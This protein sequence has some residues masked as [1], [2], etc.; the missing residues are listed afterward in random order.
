MTYPRQ[1]AYGPAPGCP[2][3]A[4]DVSGDPRFPGPDDVRC[5]FADA[6]GGQVVQLRGTVAAEGEPGDLALPL[7]QSTVTVHRLE[8]DGG[9]QRLGPAVARARTDAQGA[10]SV[11]AV[12]PPGTYVVRVG[13]D[14][15]AWAEQRVEIGEEAPDT[16]R[17]LVPVDPALR[18]NP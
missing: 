1:P 5:S 3:G 17:L 18:S 12:L 2:E 11:S 7:A 6:G 13:T 8:S 16:L 14:A 10:F 4:V 9:A 15:D